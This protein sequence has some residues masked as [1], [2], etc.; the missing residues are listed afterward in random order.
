MKDY[1]D[2]IFE[3]IC[4]KKYFDGSEYP[5][6]K[7]PKITIK[8][9]KINI[10]Q[11]TTGIGKT[12]LLNLLGLMDKTDLNLSEEES[13]ILYRPEPNKPTISYKNDIYN[14]SKQKEKLI[15]NDFGFL[16]QH[17][18]LL[19]DMTC[20]ENLEIRYFF[21]YPQ[22]TKKKVKK[23]IETLLDLQGFSDLKKS[24]KK[25]PPPINR[26]PASLSGGQRHR[27]ALMRALIHNPRIIFADEPFASVDEET[28]RNIFKVLIEK[29]EKDDITIIA[30]VHN[31]EKHLFSKHKEKINTIDLNKLMN[32]NH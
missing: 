24:E 30:V 6:I 12:S 16:F 1:K 9:N 15:R 28:A 32:I 25:L 27:V 7:Y 11:G 20:W 17:D 29:V 31:K 3:T 22:K 13:D 21:K 18:H 19:D 26:S 5:P 2:F 8:R 4:L 14:N 23:K 10:I